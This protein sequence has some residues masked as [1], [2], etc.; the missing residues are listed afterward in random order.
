MHAVKGGTA[1]IISVLSAG[2]LPFIAGDILK[3]G[4]AALAAKVI[5]P[6]K[7]YTD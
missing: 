3:T 1:G 6:K 4:A 2:A 5:T 7:S